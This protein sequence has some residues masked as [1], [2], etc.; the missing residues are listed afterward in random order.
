MTRSEFGVLTKLLQWK[1]FFFISIDFKAF[2]T[3]LEYPS[4]R[5]TLEK[6]FYGTNRLEINKCLTIFL[7]SSHSEI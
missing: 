6:L 1:Y 7:A 4:N 5:V 3:L 2:L